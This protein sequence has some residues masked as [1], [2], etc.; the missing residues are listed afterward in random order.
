M[1]V[2]VAKKPPTKQETVL[3]NVQILKRYK[4]WRENV[5]KHKAMEESEPTDIPNPVDLVSWA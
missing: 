1:K 2:S 5:V 4:T 3:S